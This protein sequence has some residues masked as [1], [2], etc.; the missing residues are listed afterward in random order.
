MFIKLGMVGLLGLWP[1][2]GG[3]SRE[4]PWGWIGQLPGQQGKGG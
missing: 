1:L 2:L 4:E 3:F